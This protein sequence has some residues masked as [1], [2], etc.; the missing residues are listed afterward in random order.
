MVSNRHRTKTARGSVT[1]LRAP[2]G[3]ADRQ[4]DAE[5]DV[6]EPH[7]PD[8]MDFKKVSDRVRMR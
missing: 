1:D 7:R 8:Q 2:A 5:G 3:L 6:V 4:G